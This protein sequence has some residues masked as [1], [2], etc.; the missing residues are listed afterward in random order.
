MKKKKISLK[1]LIY[2]NRF[3][4]ALSI[5]AAVIIWIVVAI[6]ASPENDRII[7][8][9]PVKIEISNNVSNL[10]L[11]MFGNTDFTVEVKVHGKRY[12]VA[13]SV[14]TKDDISVVAKTNYVDST[15]SQTL[16]LEVTAKDPSKA[17]YEIV[18]LSQDSINVYFDYYKEGEYTLQPDVVYDGASY[19]TNGLIAETP[20]LSANTVKL[21]GPVTEMAKIKKVVARVTLNKKIS[22]T[23]TLDAEIIPLSEYGGKLQYITVNDGLADITMTLPIYQRAELPTT[24]T[25]KNAPAAYAS[26]PPAFTCSPARLNFTMDATKLSSITELSVADIDFYMLGAGRNEITIDLTTLSGVKVMSGET[27]LKVTVEMNGVTSQ[28][29]S[30]SANNIS[31]INVP[32]GYKAVV[33][34]T[35]IPSVEVVGP[36][37][38][39]ERITTDQ[40]FAEVDLSSADPTQSH[41]T[42]Y[43][44]AYVKDS[45]NCWVHNRYTVSYRL[46]KVQ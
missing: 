4:L 18:S 41:G 30:V 44:R 22:A 23:T 20:V 31:F 19:V 14:L 33:T 5:I 28:K 17:N 35:R 15:G 25:F 26:N 36:K 16:K 7:K 43:A 3:V 40:L 10:G 24:V 13:E 9:V 1:N 38:N 21:S 2:D 37:E 27:K 6:Q 11:Q 46:E 42:A 8:D 32:A 39:L 12:E 45:N 34:Q 29:S